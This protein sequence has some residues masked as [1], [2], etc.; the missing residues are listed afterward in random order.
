MDEGDIRDLMCSIAFY[1]IDKNRKVVL[2][3]T[4][5]ESST[6][7]IASK[8]SR[9]GVVLTVYGDNAETCEEHEE[10]DGEEEFDDE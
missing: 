8:H 5:E 4:D 9:V 3:Q 7:L 2:E 1:A 10:D 6:G